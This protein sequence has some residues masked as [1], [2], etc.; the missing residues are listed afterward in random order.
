MKQSSIHSPQ[1]VP[2]RRR[3]SPR[4]HRVRGP[5]ENRSDFCS[6]GGLERGHAPLARYH[7]RKE[8][9]LSYE[10]S[11][12]VNSDAQ[13]EADPSDLEVRY[14]MGA[15]QNLGS[16]YLLFKDGV[17]NCPEVPKNAYPT[18]PIE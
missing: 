11:G 4:A 12:R 3:E 7:E 17:S 15:F 18:F 13:P 9:G 16:D 6:S 5:G 10:N 2:R 1:P 14:R 8:T